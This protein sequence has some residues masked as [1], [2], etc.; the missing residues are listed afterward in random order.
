MTGKIDLTLN[1]MKEGE[2]KRKEIPLEMHI[3]WQTNDNSYNQCLGCH[4][5]TKTNGVILT[6]GN[7]NNQLTKEK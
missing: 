2:H 3:D 6:H 5:T 4:S 7:K 1:N